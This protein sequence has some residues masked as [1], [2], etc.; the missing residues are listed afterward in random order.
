METTIKKFNEKEDGRDIIVKF[1]KNDPN[2]IC[3]IIEGYIVIYW[4]R[5]NN[6]LYT[7]RFDTE[8]EAFKFANKV[9]KK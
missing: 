8:A 7:K 1:V 5:K 3:K 9:L 6:Q 2:S 4:G